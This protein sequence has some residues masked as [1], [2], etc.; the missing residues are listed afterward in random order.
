METYNGTSGAVVVLAT[1]KGDVKGFTL[2][3]DADVSK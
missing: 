1:D 3:R 2:S